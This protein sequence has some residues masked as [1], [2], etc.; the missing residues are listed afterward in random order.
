MRELEFRGLSIETNKFIYE[1]F[2]EKIDPKEVESIFW[3]CFIHD[4]AIKTYKV[5]RDSVGQYTGLKD[6]NDVKIFEGDIFILN[7]PNLKYVVEW[8]YGIIGFKGKQN[9]TYGS[10]IGLKVWLSDIEVIGNVHE[11]PELLI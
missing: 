3:A 9:K 7:D 8:Y 4:K 1:N 2:I 6:R 5:Q 10:Y 11:N